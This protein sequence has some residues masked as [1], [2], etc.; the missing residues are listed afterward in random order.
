[1]GPAWR[2]QRGYD[3]QVDPRVGAAVL[4]EEIKIAGLDVHA[5]QGRSISGTSTLLP[6]LGL[7]CCTCTPSQLVVCIL[8][9][10]V[11][12]VQWSSSLVL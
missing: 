5:M 2:Q 4:V 6:F 11:L 1:M 8:L 9:I 12:V 10:C 7:S 3:A